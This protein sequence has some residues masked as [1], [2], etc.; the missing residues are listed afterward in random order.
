[1][2]STGDRLRLGRVELSVTKSLLP[3]TGGLD[4]LR[5]TDS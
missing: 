5:D 2:L 3:E 4:T 1:V